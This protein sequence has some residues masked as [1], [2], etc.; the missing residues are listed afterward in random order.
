MLSKGSILGCKEHKQGN[1]QR[2]S[3]SAITYMY[4]ATE[5]Q[6]QTSKVA[7]LPRAQKGR[8]RKKKASL[9]V[10]MCKYA[11][12]HIHKRLAEARLVDYFCHSATFKQI[13][14]KANETD[15]WATYTAC[16]KDMRRIS[17]EP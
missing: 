4:K 6:T 13:Y 11:H 9:I 16:I 3:G 1:L 2:C 7:R 17:D 15:I 5:K 12:P 10:V 8:S 14:S